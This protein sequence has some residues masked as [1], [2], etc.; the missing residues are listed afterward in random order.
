MNEEY[1]KTTSIGSLE[2]IECGDSESDLR[3]EQIV[4][5]KY[6][7]E[8]KIGSGAWGNV[9]LATHV[10][11][12][13]KVAIKSLHFFHAKNEQAL[14]RLEQEAKALRQI[15]STYVIKTL[16]YGLSPTP[17][18][19]MEYFPSISL[20]DKVQ[21]QRMPEKDVLSIFE[22]I[23]QGLKVAHGLGFVHRDLKPSNILLASDGEMKIKIIDFGLAKVLDTSG[24]HNL[25]MTGEI[26]GSPPYMAP[27]Q[28]TNR[29]VDQRTDIYAL[30]CLMFE[31]ATGEKLF[32]AN[33]SFEYLSL[34]VDTHLYKL[35]P[36]HNIHPEMAKVI[37]KCV[38]N[39]PSERYQ[40]VREILDDLAIVK[41]GGVVKV[42]IRKPKR[43]GVNVA[44]VA[45]CTMAALALVGSILL[46]LNRELIIEKYCESLNARA[47]KQVEMGQL[48][49]AMETYKSSIAWQANVQNKELYKAKVAL[50]QLKKRMNDPQALALEEQ[51]RSYRNPEMPPS[52]KTKLDA[53]ADAEKNS[54]RALQLQLTKAAVD[55]ARESNAPKLIY[56]ICLD[57]LADALLNNEQKL[58]AVDKQVEAIAVTTDTVGEA[59][60]LNAER[61]IALAKINFKVPNA[62]EAEHA[63]L[64][65]AEIA[66]KEKANST[67]HESYKLLGMLALDMQESGKSVKYHQLAVSLNG[68]TDLSLVEDMVDLC[69]AYTAMNDLSHAHEWARKAYSLPAFQ[70]A[71]AT[72][73]AS[74]YLLLAVTTLHSSH[75]EEGID[76]LERAIKLEKELPPTN[77][78]LSQAKAFLR[79]LKAQEISME[80]MGVKNGYLFLDIDGKFVRGAEIAPSFYV[81]LDPDTWSSDKEQADWLAWH[82]VLAKKIFASFLKN[83]SV[84]GQVY[85]K[86]LVTPDRKVVVSKF[87]KVYPGAASSSGKEQRAELLSDAASQ[88]K[89]RN[90]VQATMQGIE[91]DMP[92][93]K[94]KHKFVSYE[95][96][97]ILACDADTFPRTGAIDLEFLARRGSG[98]GELLL[99]HTGVKNEKFIFI[100]TKT[101]PKRIFVND[102]EELGAKKKI[103]FE[104]S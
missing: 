12:G 36:K 59:D 77:N 98:P 19:V 29:A 67:L 86:V 32:V 16:D 14:Q 80:E 46:F 18:L 91:L 4:S 100:E 84:P 40:S 33:T 81:I 35:D 93:P 102:V 3:L 10:G 26:L 82:N 52:I 37:L 38:Q 75:T 8:Q 28:W 49:P 62:D 56:A 47:K 68:K 65:A 54:K 20:S 83:C 43:K 71:S 41:T 69:H 97:L 53:A 7:I 78:D 48:Q 101:K 51:I 25:T 58:A 96:N 23:C 66:K 79:K 22:Q 57:R 74:M 70:S 50:L 85:A 72:T 17:Y 60:V 73:K 61:L 104:R 42:K 88:S 34:H 76:F 1:Q 55:E 95:V 2:N 89:F 92:F 44:T 21:E 103:G 13:N 9:Y 5:E 24:S 15:D 87:G 6:K 45:L 27:E 90:A 99:Y 64:R 63:L 94:T 31:V 30:G 11:L 39:Q